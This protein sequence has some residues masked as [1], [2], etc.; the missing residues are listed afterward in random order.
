MILLA[1]VVIAFLFLVAL[2]AWC[3]DKD[4]NAFKICSVWAWA[5]VWPLLTLA[6]VVHLIHTLLSL[7]TKES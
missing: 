3:I 1:Y 6:V 2:H 4:S 5:A 7:P